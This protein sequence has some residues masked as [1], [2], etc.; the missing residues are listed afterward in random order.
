LILF[1]PTVRNRAKEIAELLSDLDRVRQERR[2]AKAAKNKYIGVGS[3]GPSFSSGGSKYGGFGS[4]SL[5]G[6]GGHDDCEC[7]LA[8]VMSACPSSDWVCFICMWFLGN[9]GGSSSRDQYASGSG[10]F[11]QSDDFEEYD[12]GEWEDRPAPSATR[13]SPSTARGSISSHR[14]SISVTMKTPAQK[15]TAPPP[16]AKEVDLFSMGDDD[17]FVSPAAP[18]SINT[19]NPPSVSV[20]LDG[21][22]CFQSIDRL[23]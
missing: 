14:A 22:S 9:G 13:T 5:G 17:D 16:K 3:D 12:A 7:W 1:F 6:G 20:G 10:T 19:A 23:D 18:S 11:K 8:A 15:P 21:R 4:D 2:K